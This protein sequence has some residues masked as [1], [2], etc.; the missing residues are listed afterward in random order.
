MTD[1][2]KLLPVNEKM[3]EWEE[4]LQKLHRSTAAACTN[5]RL[6][7]FSSIDERG[8]PPTISNPLPSA[9]APLPHS[10]SILIE[11]KHKRTPVS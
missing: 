3:S 8:E 5:K 4:F 9:G 7:E 10:I 1:L 6:P 11:K 2:S